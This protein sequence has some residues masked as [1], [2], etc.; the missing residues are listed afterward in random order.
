MRIVIPTMPARSEALWQ[1][2]QR[3]ADVYPE[4]N[5]RVLPSTG[6]SREDVVRVVRAVAECPGRWA[7]LME[8]DAWPC[9]GFGYRAHDVAQGIP[10][11]MGG[12]SLFSRRKA[13]IEPGMYHQ[14]P[15]QLSYCV[16]M[17]LRPAA[18]DG[19]SEWL[20]RW[21]EDHPQHY[22]AMDTAIGDWLSA[23]G[24]SYGVHS[25]SLAQH[26]E[27]PSS[28]GG[29]GHKRMSTT[30]TDAFGDAPVMP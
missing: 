2:C 15:R 27:G 30:Y 5:L 20:P 28:F 22:H 1:L 11:N 6:D 29:R 23:G 4:A 18:F 21:Y 7:M 19:M 10:T 12:C 3:L 14:S 17:L 26:R 16:S 8:D 25:P 24:W 9:Q 13:H